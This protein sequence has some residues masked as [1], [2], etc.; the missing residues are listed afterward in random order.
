[1]TQLI[2]EII[3]TGATVP[4]ALKRSYRPPAF[5]GRYRVVSHRRQQLVAA[6]IGVEFSAALPLDRGAARGGRGVGRDAERAAQ[7]V[8]AAAR[9]AGG[10]GRAGG[11]D[12]EHQ[13]A[14][15]RRS[16]WSV[17]WRGPPKLWRHRIL[18][19]F[20]LSPKRAARE[21]DKSARSLHK[22]MHALHNRSPPAGFDP[23]MERVSFKK[24]QRYRDAQFARSIRSQRI[25]RRSASPSTNWR[26]PRS[27]ARSSPSCGWRSARTP[28]WRPGTTGTRRRR[29]RC[30]TASCTAG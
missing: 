27:R 22:T 19:D 3:S 1:M 25:S 17:S 5:G 28:A 10:K 30:A 8:G 12:A 24:T 18:T 21:A 9:L 7:A 11:A 16:R 26:W 14:R 4:P 20:T 29:W 6:I 13:Q 2:E 15:R 23:G